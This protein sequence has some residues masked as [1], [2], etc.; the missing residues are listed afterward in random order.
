MR[1]SQC[2][3][4]PTSVTSAPM[5]RSE[6]CI[7]GCRL[8][9]ILKLRS[10]T[11]EGGG[12]GVDIKHESI[13]NNSEFCTVKII[14]WPAAELNPGT[15]ADGYLWWGCVSDAAPVTVQGGW[16]VLLVKS[17]SCW[18]RHVEPAT[19]C[20]LP[21][22]HY[23]RERHNYIQPYIDALEWEYNAVKHSFLYK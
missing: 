15:F 20:C 18:R 19:M 1:Q 2:H 17:R 12:D 21:V 6:R 13:R 7:R 5:L 10:R 14:N 11:F 4:F 23:R 9:S 8:V 22:L 16:T 3:L